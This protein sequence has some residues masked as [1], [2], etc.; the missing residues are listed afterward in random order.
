M[1]VLRFIFLLLGWLC[2]VINLLFYYTGSRTL[3]HQEIEL[4]IA[5]YIG[6]SSFAIVGLVFLLFAF[7][8]NKTIKQQSKKSLLDSFLEEER[9]KKS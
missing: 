2:I 5:Y 7:L 9:L 6:A 1:K 8:I 4:I 3:R